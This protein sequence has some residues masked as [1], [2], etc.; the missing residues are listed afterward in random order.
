[1]GTALFLFAL[2]LLGSHGARHEWDHVGHAEFH[3]IAATRNFTRGA[4]GESCAVFPSSVRDAE[5]IPL[6]DSCCYHLS[7]DLCSNVTRDQLH[8]DEGR[9]AWT[10]TLPIDSRAVCR[11]HAGKQLTAFPWYPEA[12]KRRQQ[13][14]KEHPER[15]NP[16]YW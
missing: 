8:I 3:K 1:M 7:G 11:I 5:C 15:H 2:M 6:K 13:S 9:F 4:A 10:K 16:K 12:Y 14:I